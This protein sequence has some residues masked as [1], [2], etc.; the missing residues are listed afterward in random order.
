MWRS[1]DDPGLGS[2][3]DG[4]VIIM[5]VLILVGGLL[6]MAGV[7]AQLVAWVG[8][9]LSAHQLADQRWF[10]LMLWGGIVGIALTPVFGLGTLIIGTAMVAYLVAAPDGMVA[11]PQAPTPERRT[12]VRWAARGFAL[13]G[14]GFV[15]WLLIGL[16][17]GLG[18]PLHNLTWP[19]LALQCVGLDLGVIGGVIVSAAWWGA[20]LYTYQRSDLRAYHRR[21]WIGIVATLL[22]PFF[23]LGGLVLLVAVIVF[24]R[25]TAKDLQTAARAPAM[26]AS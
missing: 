8:A 9:V 24:E 23:G 14:A 18:G 1:L 3:A 12:V 20:V 10:A 5:A 2:A 19:S 4:Y 7:A 26:P 13:A 6:A 21:L 15:L 16:L 17:R 22:M 25:S 11:Q